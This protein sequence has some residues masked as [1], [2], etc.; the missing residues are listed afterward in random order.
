MS[1][2]VR[3]LLE[4]D[5]RDIVDYWISASPDYLTA[6]GADINKLP[7]R[8]QFIAN[9]QQQLKLPYEEI[10]SYALIW[11]DNGLSIGH[12]NINKIVFA[13]E[14]YMHLHLWKKEE[15]KKGAGSTLV[16]ASLPYYFNKFRLQ[17]LY[18]EPYALNEAPNKTL[19]KVGFEFIQEH[20]TIPGAL[21]FEQIVKTWRMSK[22]RYIALQML[23]AKQL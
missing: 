23:R 1:L 18:C 21:N 19:S 10:S 13:Q 6:M 16:E 11:E 8:S 4:K 5:I 7:A 12:C 3:E 14:A 22:T 17:E 20:I 9:L 15:R 2:N